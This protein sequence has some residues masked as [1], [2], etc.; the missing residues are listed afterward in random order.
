MLALVNVDAVL[1]AALA[2][3]A[4]RDAELEDTLDP[5]PSILRWDKLVPA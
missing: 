2:L 4:I 1:F 5:L 3:K